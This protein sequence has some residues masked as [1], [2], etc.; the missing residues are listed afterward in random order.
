M[1]SLEFVDHKISASNLT[2]HSSGT[3][4]PKFQTKKQIQNDNGTHREHSATAASKYVNTYI[5]AQAHIYTRKRESKY[6]HHARP[7]CIHISFFAQACHLSLRIG[8]HELVP[9][10][11]RKPRTGAVV[12]TAE[13]S[14]PTRQKQAYVAPAVDDKIIKNWKMSSTNWTQP[15]THLFWWR[16]TPPQSTR[17][18]APGA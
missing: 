6:A 2:E 10:Q 17:S 18:P 7:Q 5:H 13:L 8:N 12:G 4:I 9:W 14:A 15:T 3:L 1:F 11:N 16:C